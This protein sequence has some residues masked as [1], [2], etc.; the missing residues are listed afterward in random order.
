MRP[1]IK[2]DRSNHANFRSVGSGTDSNNGWG[3]KVRVETIAGEGIAVGNML[4][5]AGG[6]NLRVNPWHPVITTMDIKI[7]NK[8]R[9]LLKGVIKPS[10]IYFITFQ[11]ILVIPNGPES[12]YSS[13]V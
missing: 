10:S 12:A 13:S 4:C 8:I 3:D 2:G 11:C 1:S 5:E 9:N 7:R 6:F